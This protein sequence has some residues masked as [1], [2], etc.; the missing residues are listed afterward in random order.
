MAMR[1]RGNIILFPGKD[2]YFP[3]RTRVTAKVSCFPAEGNVEKPY[4]LRLNARIMIKC[5]QNFWWCICLKENKKL[6]SFSD[7][8]KQ[9]NTFFVCATRRIRD[10]VVRS[11]TDTKVTL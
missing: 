7:I 4:V 6:F 1:S 5:T 8:P 3:V 2:C 10:Q 11:S 9:Q